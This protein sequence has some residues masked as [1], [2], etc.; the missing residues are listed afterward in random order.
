MSGN[1]DIER[2]TNNG[3]DMDGLI[4]EASRVMSVD[5]SLFESYEYLET[6]ALSEYE[7]YG[8][9]YNIDIELFNYRGNAAIYLYSYAGQ[10]QKEF[11]DDVV[12]TDECIFLKTTDPD[13]VYGGIWVSGCYLIN[14]ECY[15]EDYVDKV[16]ELIEAYGLTIPEA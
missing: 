15:S 5:P 6:D 14:I 16:N 8:E 12:I 10:A 9:N 2:L 3:L 11:G 4:A 7:F 1:P 13:F